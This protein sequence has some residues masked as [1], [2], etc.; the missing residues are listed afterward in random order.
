MFVTTPR[1][2]NHPTTKLRKA[3]GLW[4][5]CA[6]GVEIPV[7]GPKQHPL[8]R[9]KTAQVCTHLLTHS[10]TQRCSESKGMLT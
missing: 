6:K 1:V 4:I 9:G 10:S 5:F 7:E 3:M 8:P 2:F